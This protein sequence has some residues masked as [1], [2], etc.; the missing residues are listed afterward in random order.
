MAAITV[1]CGLLGA[2]LL[3]IYI[4]SRIGQQGLFRK[5]AL[6]ATQDLDKGYI[7]VDTAQRNLIGKEGIAK[8]ILRPS[9]KVLIEDEI[10]DAVAESG[11]IENGAKIKVKSYASGQVYVKVIK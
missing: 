8:T 1:F 4:A 2:I 7:G 10:Y 11:Y 3:S 5:I 9:G 6:E